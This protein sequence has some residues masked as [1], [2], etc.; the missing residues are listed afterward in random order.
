MFAVQKCKFPE[1]FI[2]SEDCKVSAE[3]SIIIYD[4]LKKVTESVQ[5]QKA[6]THFAKEYR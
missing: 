5:A 3:M 4:I 2:L 6:L 1:V